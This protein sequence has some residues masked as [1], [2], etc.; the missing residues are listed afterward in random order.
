MDQIIIKV[1]LILVLVVFA[2]ILL[3]PGSSARNQ[4][5]RTIV[6]LLFLAAGVFAVIFPAVLDSL[7]KF[8]GVGRGTDLVL[9]AFIVVFIG[10]ALTNARRRRVHDE[11]ITELARK[12][13]L[14]DPQYPETPPR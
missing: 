13:A 9:Y 4:A 5:I 11:Q 7:A 3:R 6:L 12:L 14:A 10:Q 1:A 2:V 8:V